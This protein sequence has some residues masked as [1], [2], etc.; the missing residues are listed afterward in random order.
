MGEDQLESALSFA[1]VLTL[2]PRRDEISTT[3]SLFDGDDT[4]SLR[5][6]TNYEASHFPT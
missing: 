4:F 1:Y 5:S 2:V 6:V 3:E